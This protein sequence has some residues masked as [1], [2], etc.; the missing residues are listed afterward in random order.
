MEW[1]FGLAVFMCWHCNTSQTWL[2]RVGSKLVGAP[3]DSPLQYNSMRHKMTSMII[4]VPSEGGTDMIQRSSG[5][6]ELTIITFLQVPSSSF[7][8]TFLLG[9]LGRNLLGD[10]G[11]ILPSRS[12]SR[13]SSDPFPMPLPSL[14][15]EEGSWIHSCCLETKSYTIGGDR[16]IPQDSSDRNPKPLNFA[17]LPLA[18]HFDLGLP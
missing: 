4:N 13:L 5:K 14:T 6:K 11:S 8:H 17:V 10:V 2:W 3:C 1:S 16:N 15:D 12:T 9:Q 7:P 18:L